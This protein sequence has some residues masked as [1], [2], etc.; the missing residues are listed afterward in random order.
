[1]SR[2]SAAYGATAL[3]TRLLIVDRQDLSRRGLVIVLAPEPDI[4]VVG[5]CADLATAVELA[6]DLRPN[7]VLLDAWLP[8]GGAEAC[9]QIRAAAPETVVVMLTAGPGDSGSGADGCLVKEAPIEEVAEAVRAAAGG[10]T[11]Q[12]GPTSHGAR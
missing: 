5:A 8:E 1:M 3:P 2:E 4:A 6:R 10:Q 12:A 11:A 9:A 7:V